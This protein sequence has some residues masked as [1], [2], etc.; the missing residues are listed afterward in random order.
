MEFLLVPFILLG[1]LALFVFALYNNLVKLRMRVKEAWSDMDVQLKRRN[2][3]IP[4]LVE[5]VKGYMKHEAD[6]L[7]KITELRAGLQNETDP[8]KLSEL[9]QQMTSALSSLKI[10]VEN[11]PDLKANQNFIQLQE[12][13]T[14]TEDKIAYSR[15]F[16]NQT[17]MSYNTSIQ[18]FP[19]VLLAGMLGFKEEVFFEATEEERQDVKVDFNTTKK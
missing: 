10:A 17:V 19:N 15:R 2:S 5:S 13:L 1:A 18:T 7:T 14:S 8:K 9:D 11:Y 12:E 4:N 16:Y 6:L 3:L